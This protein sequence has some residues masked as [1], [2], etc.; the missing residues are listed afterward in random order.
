M[1]FVPRSIVNTVY[2]PPCLSACRHVVDIQS[3]TKSWTQDVKIWDTFVGDTSTV[4]DII[5]RGCQVFTGQTMWL[6]G[7][8]LHPPPYEYVSIDNQV[9][10]QTA[11]LSPHPLGYAN[12]TH[13]R[14]LNVTWRHMIKQL[15][16]HDITT[17][18]VRAIHT[19]KSEVVIIFRIR[20][21]GITPLSCSE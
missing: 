7:W 10:V 11:A 17:M 2:R 12:I 5:L 1:Q 20:G 15:H 6:L 18:S 9:H 16:N 8:Q 19:S 14:L 4:N 21:N 13:D 3:P